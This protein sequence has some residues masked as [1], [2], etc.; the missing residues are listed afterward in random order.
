MEQSLNS[1]HVAF[2][3]LYGVNIFINLL[4]KIVAFI[5]QCSLGIYLF[6]V[7]LGLFDDLPFNVTVLSKIMEAYNARILKF[8]AALLLWNYSTDV[9][10]IATRK[11]LGL[12]NIFSLIFSV[13]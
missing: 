10:N 12:W 8:R 3:F 2:D 1:R 13:Y 6:L 7:V 11:T 9:Y 4:A 5:D